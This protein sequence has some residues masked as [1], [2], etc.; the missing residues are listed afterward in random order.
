MARPYPP[1]MKPESTFHQAGMNRFVWDLRYPGPLVAEDGKLTNYDTLGPLASPGTY[2]VKLTAGELNQ[3]Q[4]FELLKDPRL[5]TTQEDF[6]AQF[7]LEIQVRD[8]LSALQRTVLTLQ[9]VLE[10]LEDLV[11]RLA[12]SDRGEAIGKAA[13]ALTLKLRELE[14]E[15]VPTDRD[16]EMERLDHPPKLSRQVVELYNFLGTVGGLWRADARPT[17]GAYQRFDDLRTMLK[18]R[19]E[20]LD[21]ILGD[22][23]DE[24]N[25][26]IQDAN[27]PPV[28]VG[29]DR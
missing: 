17:D 6:Q 26:M 18:E 10:Q 2:Q 25:T 21:G 16:F 27:V 22:E 19:M 28:L 9:D 20:T 14:F 4:S 7:D 3:T 23:L 13:S 24:F 8:Q 12:D 1:S 5:S 11:E 29:H 15:F